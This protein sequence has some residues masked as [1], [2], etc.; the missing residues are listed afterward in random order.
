MPVYS[1]EQ[2]KTK[3]LGNKLD[4]AKAKAKAKAQSNANK[5]HAKE[6]K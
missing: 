4:W 2:V 3:D 5:L 1:L 6:L